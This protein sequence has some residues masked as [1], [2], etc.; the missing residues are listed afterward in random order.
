MDRLQHHAGRYRYVLRADVVQH[1]P[2]LDH[3]LLRGKLARVVDDSDLLWLAGVILDSGAGVLTDEYR[4]CTSPA[5]TC[6]PPAAHAA[7]R[8][9]I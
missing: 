6:S 1:F 2:S 4:R 3:D 9:A 5:T 8:S 7:C